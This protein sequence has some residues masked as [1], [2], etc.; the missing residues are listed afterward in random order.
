VTWG[1]RAECTM[2]A[3]VNLKTGHVVWLPSTLCCWPA[4]ADANFQP[5]IF[6]VNSSLI[7]LSGL[8]DEKEG[9]QGTHFYRIDGGRF[10]LVRDIMHQ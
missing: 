4:D 8:R 2:G 5:V 7:V 10:V 6:R 9:D 3:A 1:G